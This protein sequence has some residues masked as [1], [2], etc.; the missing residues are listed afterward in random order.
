MK[1]AIVLAATFATLSACTGGW[2]HHDTRAGY[3]ELQVAQALAESTA[4]DRRLVNAY[5]SE[6]E[7]MWYGNRRLR[8]KD[9]MTPSLRP[10]SRMSSVS[11]IY[12]HPKNL[13][14]MIPTLGQSV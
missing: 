2:I 8:L 14:R 13:H 4:L 10:R 6:P 3:A 1:R 5:G 9:R 12:G 7:T 11:S